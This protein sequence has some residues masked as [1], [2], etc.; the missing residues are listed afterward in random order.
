MHAPP[1]KSNAH[2][3]H[4]RITPLC[5]PPPCLQHLQ[6][7]TWHTGEGCSIDA[8]IPHSYSLSHLRHL[9]LQL[10][11]S[12]EHPP[13]LDFLTQLTSLRLSH[14]GGDVCLKLPPA[15]RQ[16]AVHVRGK[17]YLIP[18]P[19]AAALQSLE[20]WALVRLRVTL[21]ERQLPFGPWQPVEY[22][23]LSR[24]SLDCVEEYIGQAD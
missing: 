13:P 17:L 24:L 15:C 12:G 2:V 19:A 21:N 1:A 8:A 20:A 6:R 3:Q 18:Q 10:G 7:L 16:A 4:R 22:P 11:L 9:D 5:C 23:Q 14:S